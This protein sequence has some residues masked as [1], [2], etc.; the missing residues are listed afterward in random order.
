MYKNYLL[1]SLWY[2]EDMSEKLAIGRENDG[3]NEQDFNWAQTS[4]ESDNILK[5]NL[6][7]DVLPYLSL[8]HLSDT[9][10]ARILKI[11][12]ETINTRPDIKNI[13]EYQEWAWNL[14]D[15]VVESWQNNPSWILNYPE[16]P[17]L[18]EATKLISALNINLL[19]TSKLNGDE[20]VVFA[21][22]IL[23]GLEC[24]V[25]GCLELL[26]IAERSGNRNIKFYLYM[27][28]FDAIS[29]NNDSLLNTF[30]T[31]DAIQQ[32]KLLSAVSDLVNW[33]E[34]FRKVNDMD[35]Q[36][37]GPSLAQYF[38]KDR[39]KYKLVND[40]ISTTLDWL[41]NRK[42]TTPLVKLV[43]DRISKNS[44][45]DI[46]YHPTKYYDKENEIDYDMSYLLNTA[47]R[48]SIKPLIEDK[49]SLRL[50]DIPLNSQVQLLK[51]MT[52]ADNGR[53]NHLCNSLHKLDV[54][55]RL[56]F[57]EAFLAADF[58]EDFGDALLDIADSNR[59][60]NKQKTEILGQIDSCRTAIEGITD[61]FSHFRDKEFAH[62]YARAANERLTDAIKVFSEIAK[63]GETRANLDWAGAPVFNYNT[64]IEALSLEAKSLEIISGTMGA[65]ARGEEG[66]FA[67]E[68]LTPDENRQRTLYNFYSKE[69]GYVLLYTR[70]EGSGTFDA[71]LEYGKARS[72]Y[73]PDTVN[74]GVEA[75]ISFI[76]NPN[77]PFDLPNPFRP[78][79][80]AVKNPNYYDSTTMDK[81][82]AIRLDREGRAPDAPADDPN[83]DPINPIGTISVDLAA[84]ND[85]AD[86]PSG[87]IARLF[88]VGNKLREE[89]AGTQ[90]SLNHNTHYFEQDRYGTAD[91]FKDLVNYIDSLASSW[92]K[93]NPPARDE[94]SF[95][96]VARERNRKIGKVAV[97]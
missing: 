95:T 88:S 55:S 6:A 42:E 26:P 23:G 54:R 63:K 46:D 52:E 75:S 47:H 30:K 68:V 1:L 9:E 86:T 35:Q 24:G 92:A 57:A 97:A 66:A 10:K 44:T 21:H 67:E 27:D 15:S 40:N 65:V 48:P 2:N 64:A 56:K 8:K 20:K 19:S 38:N 14:N 91:G 83:R 28:I 61:L 71:M 13:D 79:Y 78:N 62:E 32:I 74:T 12:D 43:A 22:P 29:E 7:Q 81:V 82:S 59:L 34:D 80:K 85:R 4:I 53:F 94:L 18:L 41:K 76:A 51:F 70:K 69:H 72:K 96:N 39:L 87:K 16:N 50:D 45:R 49:L 25:D 37:F 58:G 90:F 5:N 11:W 77:N 3:T 31:S 36:D 89:S 17:K 93:T 33:V 84:I 73:S 60:E